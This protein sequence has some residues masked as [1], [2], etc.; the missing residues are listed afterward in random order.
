M[1]EMAW[2]TLLDNGVTDGNEFCLNFK[3]SAPNDVCGEALNDAISRQTDYKVYMTSEGRYRKRWVV[4]GATSPV[5]VSKPVINN[6]VCEMVKLG[7][8]YNCTFSGWWIWKYD[9]FASPDA[10]SIRKNLGSLAENKS[11]FVEWLSG[12]INK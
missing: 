6:W 11:K 8:G 1:N 9:D 7:F 5:K 3:F 4:Q 12:M 10:T 2:N